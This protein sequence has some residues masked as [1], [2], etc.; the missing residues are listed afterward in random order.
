M[1]PKSKRFKS[2]ENIESV[3]NK[4]CLID[5]MCLG[6]VTAH[7]KKS[8]GAGGDDSLENLMPLC[9][10]HHTEIHQIGKQSF[11]KK[12]NVKETKDVR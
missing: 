11:K 8:V 6:H 5:K 2:K 4:A 1:L 10:K 9:T 3:K 7:H 12:Y